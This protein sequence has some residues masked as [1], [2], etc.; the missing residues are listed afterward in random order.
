MQCWVVGIQSSTDH[1]MGGGEDMRQG[2]GAHLS[3]S[4]LSSHLH[5][6]GLLGEAAAFKS[7][8]FL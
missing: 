8:V 2:D 5:W 6:G 3:L 4:F 1:C 7:N